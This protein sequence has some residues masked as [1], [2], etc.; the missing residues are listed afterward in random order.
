MMCQMLKTKSVRKM[1]G[2]FTTKVHYTFTIYTRK[3]CV[4]SKDSKSV[5]GFGDFTSFD[6]LFH[7]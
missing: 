5:T 4:L 1:Y 6:R 3:R 2:S 7:A